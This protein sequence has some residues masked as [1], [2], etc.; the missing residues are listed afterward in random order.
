MKWHSIKAQF[1]WAGLDPFDLDQYEP[2]PYVERMIRNIHRAALSGFFVGVFFMSFLG[3][4]LANHFLTRWAIP[5]H[6][7]SM[8]FMAGSLAE[9]SAINIHKLRLLP[10]AGLG[11]LLIM[12]GQFI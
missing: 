5:V 6:G 12:I 4:V 8:I 3:A 1:R 11:L 10:L 9:F 7:A 2:V